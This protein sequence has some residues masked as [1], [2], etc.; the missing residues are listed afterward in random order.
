MCTAYTPLVA[1]LSPVSPSTATHVASPA[2]LYVPI[3]VVVGPPGSFRAAGIGGFRLPASP[4][5][6]QVAVSAAEADDAPSASITTMLLA[7]RQS[8]FLRVVMTN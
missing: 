4:V 3:S 1:G 5:N 8:T 2:K 6:E 7:P